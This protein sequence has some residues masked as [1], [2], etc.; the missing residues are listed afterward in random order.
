MAKTYKQ[1][2]PLALVV[3]QLRFDSPHEA[4]TFLDE[5]GVAAFQPAASA[6]ADKV[7]ER[8]ERSDFAEKREAALAKLS[9]TERNAEEP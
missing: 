8:A 5:Y 6:P 1:G 9:V 4:E 3:S 7:L 2:I